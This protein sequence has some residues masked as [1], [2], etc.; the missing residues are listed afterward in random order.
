MSNSLE[1][2]ENNENQ[3]ASLNDL[4]EILIRHITRSKAKKIKDVFNWL[5]QNI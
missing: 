5:I 1:E 4:L 3:Q 2:R